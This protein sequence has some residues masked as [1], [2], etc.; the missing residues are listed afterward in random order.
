M[1]P[2]VTYSF[3]LSR[4]SSLPLIDKRITGKG[5]RKIH[6]AIHYSAIMT[7]L[8]GKILREATTVIVIW[9]NN[10]ENRNT[11]SKQQLPGFDTSTLAGQLMSNYRVQST[12]ILC[13]D[14]R[15][16]EALREDLHDELHLDYTCC[17]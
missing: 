3:R 1:L 15:H 8:Y 4:V 7:V 5:R 17:S 10:K 2:K 12:S 16:P 6:K 11:S 14:T 13:Y 9:C